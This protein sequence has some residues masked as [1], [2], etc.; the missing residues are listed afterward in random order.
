M[1]KIILSFILIILTA[2][3]YSQNLEILNNLNKLRV[4]NGKNEL[5]S[6]DVLCNISKDYASYVLSYYNH[7]PERN[8]EKKI[9]NIF[10]DTEYEYRKMLFGRGL[11]EEEIYNFGFFIGSFDENQKN[12]QEW[13][14][15]F[16]NKL[17][18]NFFLEFITNTDLKITGITL[19]HQKS[20]GKYTQVCIIMITVQ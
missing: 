18:I 15:Y 10:F 12:E 8:M 17:L 19:V 20:F 13:L 4:D 14:E 1:K 11:S 3:S 2:L 16:K 9:N 5:F 6:D 7:I